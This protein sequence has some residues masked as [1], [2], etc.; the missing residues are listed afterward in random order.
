MVQLKSAAPRRLFNVLGGFKTVLWVSLLALALS[1]CGAGSTPMAAPTSTTAPTLAA[2]SAPTETPLPSPTATEAPTATPEPTAT[3]TA[4]PIPPLAVLSDGFTVWCNPL[5]Y[6]GVNQPGPQAP[7]VARQLSE[8]DGQEHVYI[9]ADFCTI[10]Y[11]FNQSMPAGA[12]FEMFDGSTEPFL[13]AAL[14]P[15]DGQPQ[16]A[17][18]AVD[19]PYVV[20]PP[21]W[22]VTYRLAVLAP[23]GQEL[24]TDSVTFGKVIPSECP[25]GG[26]PDPVTLKCA[27]TD[28]WEVEPHPGVHYPYA[29]WTPGPSK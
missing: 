1:G 23:D 13:K 22:E 25:F 5:D 7:A 16:V 15:A 29:T 18:V 21:F 20:N 27:L 9:P 19:H 26:L 12:Q 3:A 11:T 4:T 2:T 10:V 28:P 14:T 8:V 24:R 6:A 17:F